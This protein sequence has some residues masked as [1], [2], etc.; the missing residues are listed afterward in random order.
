MSK[1]DSNKMLLNLILGVSAT[2]AI[3]LLILA[4]KVKGGLIGAIL[5]SIIVLALIYW[6]REVKR[7]FSVRRNTAEEHDWLYDFIEEGED[8]IF[9]AKVPGP[10]EEV[11]VKLTDGVLEI[12]GGGN[13]FRKVE[14]SRDAKIVEKSYVNGV[15]RLK[16]R[17]SQI[18]QSGLQR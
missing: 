13:F 7:I 14:L 8:V 4:F 17:V 1:N 11:R 10:P 15:L 6:M 18:K 9:V 2:L 5:G 16:L 3:A 12:R